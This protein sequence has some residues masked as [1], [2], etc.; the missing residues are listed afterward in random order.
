[1]QPAHGVDYHIVCFLCGGETDQLKWF[2]RV[3]GSLWTHLIGK[4]IHQGL[5][6]RK[7]RVK[8][9]STKKETRKRCNNQE[10]SYWILRIGRAPQIIECTQPDIHSLQLHALR[11]SCRRTPLNWPFTLASSTS[12]PFNSFLVAELLL[13]PYSILDTV[14]TDSSQPANHLNKYSNKAKKK[15]IP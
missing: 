7:L 8:R 12:A 11:F 6:I 1:M 14:R 3:T 5:T 4:N 9:Y 13:L 2:Q 10:S 15:P